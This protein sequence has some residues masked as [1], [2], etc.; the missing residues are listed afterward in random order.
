[1][2]ATQGYAASRDVGFAPSIG[3]GGATNYRAGDT[4]DHM[5]IKTVNRDSKNENRVIV[6]VEIDRGFHI[7]ANPASL[8]Y[9]IPTTLNITNQAPRRVVY[10]SPVLFKPKFADEALEVYEGTV[11]IAA[12]FPQGLLLRVSNL[13]GTVTAQACTETICL[14][15]AA[16]PLAWHGSM[17]DRPTPP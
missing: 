13:F 10:P 11:Q 4:A 6:T 7:N 3:A 2:L 17:P 12:E 5:R 1:M 8:D 16:L 15:P 14:P 9:L